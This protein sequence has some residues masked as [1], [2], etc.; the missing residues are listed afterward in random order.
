MCG[1]SATNVIKPGRPLEQH[2]RRWRGADGVALAVA[3]LVGL[4]LAIALRDHGFDDPY[5]T[6]R[7]AENLAAGRGLVYNPGERVL[8]TT[9]PL[10]AL[11]LAPF[12]AMGLHL[13]A[14]SNTIAC[15]GFGLGGLALY[16]LGRIWET[17]AA[18][19]AA[20]LILVL[21]PGML[22]TIGSEIGL[23]LALVLWGFVATAG[24]RYHLAAALLALATLVRADGAMALVAAGV[25]VAAT[26]RANTSGAAKDSPV[27]RGG[28][29]RAAPLRAWGAAALYAALLAPWVI[30]A[31]AYFGDPLPATL[32]AKQR[33]ALLPESPPFLAGLLRALG[34]YWAAPPY[35]PLLTLAAVGLAYG[36]WRRRPWLLPIGW[37]LLMAAAYTA[38]GVSAYFWY[39]AQPFVALVAALGLGVEAAVALARRWGALAAGIALAALVGLALLAVGG[40]L[41]GQLGRP[42]PRL[43]IYRGAGEWLAANT[44][45][46]AAVGMLEVGV[47]G[48]YSR[49]P[50]VDFAGLI[51]PEVAARLTV[52]DGYLSAAGWAI[53]R[54]RPAW[55]VLGEALRPAVEAHPERA[56]R[57][58][59]V[60]TIPDPEGRL[61]Q[62]I[63]RCVW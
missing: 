53:D 4:G 55:L 11:L 38:L 3:L 47:I 43:A 46:D 10:Y 44:P 26:T 37:G 45:P 28:A 41:R 19:L 59:V 14:V 12:A 5:I 58:A 39:F 13:P 17:P 31:W 51:Q 7:Y 62:T 48:F 61:T 42:D 25:F 24:G 23:F 15:L 34:F 22:A 18:G 9:A 56:A 21:F 16:Q 35:R 6:Y 1:Y 36:L 50:V 20:G 2:A 57:C 63:Y 8:S 27:R 54:Y 29:R 32:A 30:F 52:A 60:T 49:R 33:Q 40:S